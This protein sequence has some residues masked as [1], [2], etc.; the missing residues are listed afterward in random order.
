MNAVE[1]YYDLPR[2]TWLILPNGRMPQRTIQFDTSALLKEANG[3]WEGL[4]VKTRLGHIHL[5]VSHL[6]PSTDFYQ[7]LLGFD[8]KDWETP[9]ASFLAADGYHHHVALNDWHGPYP[10]MAPNQTGLMDFTITVG[11]A[12]NLQ[13][14]NEHLVSGG[15]PVTND[16]AR[17][18]LLD[19]DHNQI[20]IDSLDD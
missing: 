6:T 18:S 13:A 16:N 19:P 3:Q 5:R 1:V 20:F 12:A 11:S 10:E 8:L 9:H 2:E 4:A 14:L 15:W 7:Q 17:L